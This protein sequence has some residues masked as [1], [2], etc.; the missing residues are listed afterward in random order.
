MKKLFI[1][2]VAVTAAVLVYP[3]G[4]RIVS[5]EESTD[6]A[7][8]YTGNTRSFTSPSF[9]LDVGEIPIVPGEESSLPETTVDV[10]PGMTVESGPTFETDPPE[11]IPYVGSDDTPEPTPPDPVTPP[12]ECVD[13]DG[14]D[15][16][17]TNDLCPDEA[18]E[19][20][21][22]CPIQTQIDD[23]D[24][25]STERTDSDNDKVPDIF[26][27]CA[28][29]AEVWETANADSLARVSTSIGVGGMASLVPV[30]GVIDGCATDIDPN[31]DETIHGVDNGGGCSLLG[32]MTMNPI[33]FLILAVGL[34][35]LAIK[36]EKRVVK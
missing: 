16:C 26:D 22:G 3:G 23:N 20:D 34:I 18:A 24:I 7:I 17:G 8:T 6:D 21:D 32:T 35:P 13:T 14:D 19:T 5:G 1:L 12:L 25:I 29:E 33:G 11:M 30:D 31:K 27:K 28:D 2:M 9:S 15:V 4:I 10:V 36:R